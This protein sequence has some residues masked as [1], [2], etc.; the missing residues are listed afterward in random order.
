[1]PTFIDF[2]QLAT[3][4][5][6]AS[7][8]DTTGPDGSRIQGLAPLLGTH[9]FADAMDLA[10]LGWA[11]GEAT[12]QAMLAALAPLREGLV[13]ARFTALAGPEAARL[14]GSPMAGRVPIGASLPGGSPRGFLRVTFDLGAARDKAHGLAVMAAVYV[15]YALG[16]DTEV[17]VAAAT[18]VDAPLGETSPG[19]DVL[20]VH[21]RVKEASHPVDA[22]LAFPLCHPAFL[23]RLV[24]SVQEQNGHS[25]VLTRPCQ[26][27]AWEDGLA[28]RAPADGFPDDGPRASG[29]AQVLLEILDAAGANLDPPEAA[30]LRAVLEQ[31]AADVALGLPGL[32]P[33]H[34]S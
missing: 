23:R 13:R 28:M 19:Q 27:T 6:A 11:E 21:V 15:L 30:S 22:S 10:N 12:A 32:Q 31:Y 16:I 4:L 3:F 7:L 8:Q 14:A 20:E 24:A 33:A 34:V 2:D 5:Q 26:V 9:T 1:M 29:A 18:T 25:P 17:W